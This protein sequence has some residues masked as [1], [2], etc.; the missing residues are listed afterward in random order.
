MRSFRRLI[1]VIALLLP[2]AAPLQAQVKARF[3]LVITG[4]IP[5][6]LRG[7]LRISRQ[8]PAWQGSLGMEDR[9]TLLTVSAIRNSGDS[10]AF[11]VPLL[12][13]M[14]FRGRLQDTHFA[15]EAVAAD[16][17]I[18]SWTANRLSD[19]Q[20]YYPSAPRFTLRQIVVAGVRAPGPLPPA[21]NGLLRP[22]READS[23]YRARA[24]AAGWRPLSGLALSGDRGLRALGLLDRDATH[25]S[26]RATLSAI[27]EGIKEPAVRRR[28]AALFHPA[29]TWVIDIHDAALRFAMLAQPNFRLEAIVPALQAFGGAGS[30]SASTEV[31]LASAYRLVQLRASDSAAY[32]ALLQAADSTPT[33]S[34][35]A[36]LTLISAYQAALEWHGMALRFLLAE[37]WLP[38]SLPG[39]SV[40]DLVRALPLGATDSLPAIRARLLGYAQAFPHVRTP[41]RWIDS[42][43][44]LDNP[45]ARQWLARHGRA[46]LLLVLRRL[47]AAFDTGTAVAEGGQEFRLTTIGLEAA[48]RETGFLEPADEI[49]IEPGLAPVLA[50]QT[51]VHEWIHILHEH[52][53]DQAGLAW[54]I[55]PAGT[56]RYQPMTPLLAEGLA[57]WEAERV[58]APLIARLPL[59]G[60]FE[61]EKRA[62]MAADAPDDP[63]LLGYRLAGGLSARVGEPAL[64][65]L[66]VRHADDPDGLARDRD[67]RLPAGARP[68]GVPAVYSA[69]ALVP[70]TRFSVDDTSPEVIGVRLV[71]PI[72]R[73]R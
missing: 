60:L 68:S 24:A 58:L 73:E 23:V 6:Y 32:A 49:L 71:V 35:R 56:A 3:V 2:A 30:D 21:L 28:F 62:T 11:E 12:G 34:R 39:R 50:V 47:P 46:D 17:V 36:L 55:N 48:Q 31:L 70:E 19:T 7:E 67:T 15:G 52:A 5:P 51:V 69:S 20:E 57:E 26:E 59:L 53:R 1:A 43:V 14:R 33:A 10:L 18:R 13:G 63:H 72:A 38:A 37:P 64:V 27:E 45:N 8:G 40:A 22:A 25:A 54:R 4:G 61:A 9:D 41:D 65:R 66:L 16:G 42:L 44:H 29:G